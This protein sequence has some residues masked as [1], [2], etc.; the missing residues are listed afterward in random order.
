MH[1]K[2]IL[3]RSAAFLT[4]LCLLAALCPAALAAPPEITVDLPATASVVVGGDLTLT[5]T[6]S[7][8]GLVYQWYKNDVLVENQLSATYTETGVTA[9]SDNARYSCYV[10][11]ADGS[12]SSSVC[13][14]TVIQQPVLTQ[15]IGTTALTVNEGDTISLTAYASGAN[16]LIQWFLVTPDGDFNVIQGQTGNT[17]S[18]AATEKYADADVYCQ[19]TNEAG[20]VTTSRC[21]IT[22]NGP[23]PSPSPT[24]GPPVITKDPT[25]ET[26][27]EGGSA[28]FIARADGATGIVWRF[29]S[30]D[31][32]QSFDFDL[33]GN[34]FPG[35]VISGGNSETLSLSNIP[36][37]LDGWKVA[38]SFTGQGGDAL[39]RSAAIRVQQISSTLNIITQPVGGTMT[40]EEN[41]D[42]MLS[43]QASADNGGT[44]GY[45]WYSA[46]TNSAAA[47]AA[48]PGATNSSYRPE[49]TE[50]T[51][52]YRVGVTVS[53][54]GFTSEPVY[55]STVSVT[56]TAAAPAHEHSYSTVWEHNDISHWHQCTCGDH[57]DEAF[58]TYEWTTLKAATKDADGEQRGVCTVC[59]YETTQ[60]IPA[61]TQTEDGEEPENAKT[62]KRGGGGIWLVL[63]GILAAGVVGGAAYLIRRILREDDEDDWDEEDWDENAE[64]ETDEEDPDDGDDTKLF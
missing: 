24:P 62:E 23:T 37:E 32:N 44:L 48:I 53:N 55:S 16:L 63:L 8:E 36:Y 9:D 2:T 13:T 12:C 52:Y 31:G 59:G 18:V 10:Q 38:C 29:I 20:N 54:N 61:G 49:R 40:V 21:H 41:P 27:Q 33:A 14:L 15:D 51:R 26:V 42:F 25:G 57:A 35:L 64:E 17:L 28:V 50:G 45:Q 7:G 43:I 58:H 47:M 6:A 30:P 34:Q 39:S 4:L 5:V 3:R 11:N 56:F 22:F 1:L 46:A 60:P 19:F